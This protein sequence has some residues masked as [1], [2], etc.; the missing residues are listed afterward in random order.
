M[1]RETAWVPEDVC[2]G[3]V[4]ALKQRRGQ[5][6]CVRWS[7]H[8][9]VCLFDVAEGGCCEAGVVPPR[10]QVGG[11]HRVDNREWLIRSVRAW[12]QEISGP[13]RSLR[14]VA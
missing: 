2:A 6:A 11:W 1:P 13:A 4:Y 12:K 10:V 8:N 3:Q 14:K 5:A 7:S 9:I